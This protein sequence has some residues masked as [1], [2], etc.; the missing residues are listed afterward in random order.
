MA[1]YMVYKPASAMKLS[2][3]GLGSSLASQCSETSSLIRQDE[4]LP[5]ET[6]RT[7]TLNLFPTPR[8]SLKGFEHSIPDHVLQAWPAVYDV[9]SKR[10]EEERELAAAQRRATSVSLLTRRTTRTLSGIYRSSVITPGELEFMAG[11]RQTWRNTQLGLADRNRRHDP[12]TSY[13]RLQDNEQVFVTQD[14]SQDYEIL[15][16]DVQSRLTTSD[17]RVKIVPS[18]IEV[19]LPC[20][21][22][23]SRRCRRRLRQDESKFKDGQMTS[24]VIEPQPF[25][26]NGTIPQNLLSRQKAERNSIRM[27]SPGA[28][29]QQAVRRQEQQFLLQPT[30]LSNPEW[31]ESN[32]LKT[33]TV[34]QKY[35]TDTFYNSPP[36]AEVDAHAIL[37]YIRDKQTSVTYNPPPPSSGSG[38]EDEKDDQPKITAGAILKHSSYDNDMNIKMDN[39]VCNDRN[40]VNVSGGKS[41]ETSLPLPRWTQKESGGI[42]LTIDG[43]KIQ[44]KLPTSQSNNI[45]HNGESLGEVT[46]D[47][48]LGSESE[49]PNQTQEFDGNKAMENVRETVSQPRDDG[50]GGEDIIE[51]NDQ[52]PEFTQSDPDH[53]KGHLDSTKRI[54]VVL[55]S[56]E[57]L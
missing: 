45:I 25:K 56:S 30:A 55:P 3:P 46:G 14:V 7:A 51:E 52:K 18:M 35:L 26:N 54:T 39:M 32:G 10:L 37:D 29:R 2:K 50:M 8:Q 38:C 20:L 17:G 27:R 48:S 44:H 19:T 42:D 23:D 36:K 28:I 15:Y 43:G 41:L 13:P 49:I 6:S 57:S 1:S 31:Y 47:H 21:G 12:S 11:K 34:L 16:R 5:L 4:Y 9:H 53:G 40:Q 24:E 22:N 33:P